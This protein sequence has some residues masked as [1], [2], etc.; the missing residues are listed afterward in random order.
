MHLTVDVM[1]PSPRVSDALKA[2]QNEFPAVMLYLRVEALSAVTQLV[3]DGVAT[4]GIC[5]P[6]HTTIDGIERIAGLGSVDLVPVA[7]P[8]HPLATAGLNP[9]GAGRDHVQLVL[10]DRSPLTTE[11][12][13]AV[14]STRTWRLADLGVKH[15]LLRDGIGWGNMPLPMI[16]E[17]L[18]SGRLVRLDMLD[19]ISGNYRFE[20]I[21]RTD[22]PPGP[23]ASF[24]ISR[25]RSNQ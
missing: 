19:C 23:A 16:S 17:D 10:T 24:L 14:L 25:F 4:L 8:G 20:A 1:V 9:P 15:T 7:A 3:L 22:T 21:F 18:E 2:F 6:P 11:P 5:G 13:F 12:E